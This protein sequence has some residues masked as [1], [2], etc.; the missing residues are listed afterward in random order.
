MTSTPISPTVSPRHLGAGQHSSPGPRAAAE[1]TET[2]G[3]RI[4]NLVSNAGIY[5]STTTAELTDEEPDAML[6]A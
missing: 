6:A 4:D 3:G 2:L 5:P 1:A